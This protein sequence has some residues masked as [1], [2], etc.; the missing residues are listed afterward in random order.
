MARP[1]VKGT[2][3]QQTFL[4]QKGQAN[5]AIVIG[6]SCDKFY[7]WVAE[8][9]KRYL[10]LLSGAD[11]AIASAAKAP[12]RGVQIL[13]GGPGCNE[14]TAA[15][16]RQ[17]HVDF[18]G[19]KQ[20]GFLLQSIAMEGKS[21]LVVGG[22]DEAPTMYAAYELLERLGVVF[23]LT[24]D[25]IPERKPD[26]MIPAMSVR[27]EP[28]LKYRGLHIRH[29]VM[30]WMGMD[31]F[32][33]FLDQ[34]A[35]MKSNY[36]EFYWYVGG[37]WLEY[38]HRGERSLIGDIY[39]KESGYATWRINT[40][41]FTTA[42]VKIGKGH[43]NESRAC[44]PEFQDLETAGEAY[45]AARTLLKQVIDYA[46]GRKIQVWL[47]MGDC[48][49]VPP[50]LGRF[51]K[52]RKRSPDVGTIISPGDP[53]AVEIWAAAAK[54]MIETYPEADGHWIWLAEDY[55][56]SEDP[57]TRRTISQY[58]N[59]RKLIPS[60]EE[61]RQLGYDRPTTQAQI[62]Y[63]VGLIHC[64]SKIIEAVRRSNKSVKLGIALLGRSYLFRALDSLM[65]KDVAFSSMESSGVWN[66][67]SKVPM[68]LFGGM[69][70]RQLWLIPR[71]DDDESE[72]GMQFNVG[73]YYHD[74]VVEGSLKNGVAGIAPQTG[75][76]RG[77][78]HNARFI[79]E[80]AWN[81]TLTPADFYYAYAKKV[82]GERSATH[83]GKAFLKLDEAE[84]H[85]G[86]RG[87]GNFLNY[88]DTAE[89]TLMGLFG[90]QSNPFEG[91]DET[92]QKAAPHFHAPEHL[93]TKK[94]EPLWVQANRY[95]H[96]LF[97]ETIDLLMNS[98]DH[99]LQGE[100]KILTGSKNEWEYIVGKTRQ[101][102]LHL[103]TIRTLLAGYLAY[104]KAFQSRRSGDE[105]GF[106]DQLQLAES[107]F[108]QARDRSRTTANH[109]ALN[110]DDPSEKYILFRYNVRFVLPIEEFCKFIR[111][112]V[113][114]HHGQPY[115]EKVNWDVIQPRSWMAP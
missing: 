46:H 34:Q 12:G 3:S 79:A 66:R 60:L 85:M 110:I 67:H 96:N 114:F 62:D 58:D 21:A 31:Y 4:A 65:P 38:F 105:K 92:I 41:T 102:V 25:I 24:N 95:K 6:N 68:E 36:L 22:N 43:F 11:F 23:Q 108:Y 15:A 32:R 49:S 54:S 72:L 13:L 18:S 77:L 101:L 50:N 16:Q 106:A 10:W 78:E 35:K 64:G 55:Y 2:T 33:K 29:F 45:R 71:L 104:D 17:R 69:G 91:P 83:I 26:L 93:D 51:A 80:G 109:I 100:S 48:P 5:G 53:T 81:P 107:L 56:L 98:I 44:A 113:N 14:L 111:N 99:L 115:W 59:Y 75:K 37:P 7:R 87:F 63:D 30:P 20:D 97:G 52:H 90:K 82:F 8:E 40:G 112:V 39:P 73:L 9:V 94:D 27:M 28:V 1:I 76:T 57:E 86:W 89:I 103:E 42:D 88:A 19:L 61:I 47:G 70:G 84:S 74:Q